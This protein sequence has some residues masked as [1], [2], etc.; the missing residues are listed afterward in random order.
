MTTFR[1]DVRDGIYSLLTGFASASPTLIQH[2]YRRRP[3]SFPDKL[4]AYVGSM[5]ES[6]GHT[7]GAIAIRTMVPTVVIVMKMTEPAS[8]GADAMDDTVDAFLTYAYVRPHA[9]SSSTMC[10]P[11]GCE[12]VELDDSGTLLPAVVVSFNSVAAEGNT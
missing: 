7:G 6:I 1:S 8:E 9:I 3:G 10:R 2:T 11:V 4:S 5:P 12:D